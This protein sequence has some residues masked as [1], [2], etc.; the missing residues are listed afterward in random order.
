MSTTQP[1]PGIPPVLL[2]NIYNHSSYEITKHYLGIDQSE[3]DD[4]YRTI[5]L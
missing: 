4:V 3:K 2:M 1:F 5:T